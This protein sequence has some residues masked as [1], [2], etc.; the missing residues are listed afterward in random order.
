MT[1]FFNLEKLEAEAA[2]NSSKFVD[3]LIFLQTGKYPRNRKV[4]LDLLPTLKGKSFLLWPDPLLSGLLDESSEHIMQYV[5]LAG[6]R[7][8][9]MYKFHGVVTLDISYYP[10]LRLDL[11][12]SNP[13]L[14]IVN[15][16]I[17]FKFEEIYNGKSI[18]RHQGQGS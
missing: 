5:K 18:R 8:Y 15:N 14:Q 7:D 4:K 11:V 9:G 17:K 3:L 2:G 6:M 10:D 13:L 1:L 16:Q 12:R